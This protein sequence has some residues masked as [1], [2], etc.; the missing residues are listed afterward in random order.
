MKFTKVPVFV[1]SKTCL[2]VNSTPNGSI[3]EKYDN[4]S[5]ASSTNE[6]CDV[7]LVVDWKNMSPVKLSSITELQLHDLI[8]FK[9][10]NKFIL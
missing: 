1:R 9:V 7:M 3:L 10:N 8:Q 2:D 6:D 5:V 4:M